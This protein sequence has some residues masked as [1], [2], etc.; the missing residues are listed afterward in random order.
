[1][2][3]GAV[4]APGL[5]ALDEQADSTGRRDR[6]VADATWFR[7]ATESLLT[8]WAI[9]FVRLVSA[10]DRIVKAGA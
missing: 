6:P 2:S 10:S 5:G 3:W 9:D 7:L 1:V 4:S 8:I